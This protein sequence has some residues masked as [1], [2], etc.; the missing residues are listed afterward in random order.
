MDKDKDKDLEQCGEAWNKIIA[1]ELM[2]CGIKTIS[3]GL[4][5]K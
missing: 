3:D 2:K 5:V 1:G 4:Y